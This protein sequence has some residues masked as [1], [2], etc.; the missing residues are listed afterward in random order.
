[1]ASKEII[2]ITNLKSSE[3][4]VDKATELIKNIEQNE[5]LVFSK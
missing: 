3:E 1:M 2:F 5:K 4:F